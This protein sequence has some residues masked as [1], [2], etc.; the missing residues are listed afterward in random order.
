MKL[1]NITSYI[2]FTGLLLGACNAAPEEQTETEE[3]STAFIAVT[4]AQQEMAG[5]RYGPVTTQVVEQTLACSGMVDVPPANRVSLTT[6]FGGY[7]T[8]T[9]VYPGDQVRKGHLLAKIQDPLYVDLQRSYLSGL[10]NLT[11]LKADFE[12]KQ[13]LVQTQSVSDKQFQEARRAYQE[14]EINVQALAAQ[15]TMAGFS[16]EAIKRNGVQ[17]EVEVR[18]PINGYVTVVNINQ[19]MHLAE[20]EALFELMD[21]THVHI[22]LAV[23]PNDLAKLSEG[24]KVYYR[25]AGDETMHQ[26]YIKLINKAVGE[27]K[28]I[29]VHVHPEEE[30]EG[31]ILPG[32]FVQAEIVYSAQETLVLPTT[33]VNQT[34]NGYIAYKQV[35]G[36]VEAVVFLPRFVTQNVVDAAALAEGNYLLTGAEKLISLEDE[37]EH[38]H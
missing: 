4:A 17:P 16:V 21:P 30:D 22:E 24:Q 18:S 23:F 20:G 37:G 6:V 33:G 2:L 32:T 26:G 10:S 1:V 19:G 29:M 35:E 25:I 11:Y 8:Y 9:G 15:L 7:I 38:D 31:A 36:G 13:Q 5:L 14:A 28:S 27:A 34:D 12:R 3:T